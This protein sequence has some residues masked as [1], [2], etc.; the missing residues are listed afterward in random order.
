MGNGSNRQGQ[1]RQ[2]SHASIAPERP[3]MHGEAAET[4]PGLGAALGL[5]AIGALVASFWWGVVIWFVL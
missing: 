3:A 4:G 2:M 5:M 1:T